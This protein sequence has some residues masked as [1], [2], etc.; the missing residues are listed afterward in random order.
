MK[1]N[2][3]ISVNLR[4]AIL[5]GIMKPDDG[6]DSL[7]STSKPKSFPW[8]YIPVLIGIT[9]IVILYKVLN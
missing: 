8:F 5:V 1:Y 4:K 7:F 9:L 6:K 2:K 3:S